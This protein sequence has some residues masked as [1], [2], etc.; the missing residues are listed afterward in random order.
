LKWYF[1]VSKFGITHHPPF[2]LYRYYRNKISPILLQM[3][4]VQNTRKI[5][6]CITERLTPLKIF[7]YYEG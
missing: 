2:L 5:L 1:A 4:G 7:S 3:Q 6:G